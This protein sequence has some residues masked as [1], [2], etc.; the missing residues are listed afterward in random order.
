MS[1]NLLKIFDEVPEF[2]L[3]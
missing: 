2:L 3:F 1:I